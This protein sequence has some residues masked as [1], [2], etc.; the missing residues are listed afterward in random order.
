MCCKFKY[1]NI[2]KNEKKTLLLTA[3][4][5][6]LATIQSQ[7]IGCKLTFIQ[8]LFNYFLLIKD[9]I[10]IRSALGIPDDRQNAWNKPVEL[11]N[12]ISVAICLMHSLQVHR[13]WKQNESHLTTWYVA[14]LVFL[15]HYFRIF[16]WVTVRPSNC[17]RIALK[18]RYL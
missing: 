5:L 11:T 14:E 1:V 7:N 6:Q 4:V 2:L 16:R 17:K 13:L 15:E 8:I 3:H 10:W 18:A 12:E 9:S